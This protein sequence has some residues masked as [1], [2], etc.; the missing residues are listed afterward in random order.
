VTYVREYRGVKCKL[1]QM[2]R[3]GKDTLRNLL[4]FLF[5]IIKNISRYVLYC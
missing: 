2:F 3:D 4:P 5:L 1:C